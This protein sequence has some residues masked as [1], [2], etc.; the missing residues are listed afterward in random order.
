MKMKDVPRKYRKL[1]ERAMR[2]K[3]RKA[4]MKA[5]CAECVQW[6]INEV[7]KC[8]DVGCPLYPYRSK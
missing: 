3:S 5:F 4:A 1:Y 7:E 8:T 6:Q 2:G